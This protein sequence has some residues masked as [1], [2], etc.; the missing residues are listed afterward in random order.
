MEYWICN[1][2]FLCTPFIPGAGMFAANPQRFIQ[3]Y[4][5]FFCYAI[6]GTLTYHIFQQ[7][8][9]IHTNLRALFTFVWFKWWA[10]YSTIYI[11]Y[12]SHMLANTILWRWSVA[13]QWKSN[14]NNF[15]RWTHKFVPITFWNGKVKSEDERPDKTFYFIFTAPRLASV[16][17][18]LQLAEI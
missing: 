1:P 14:H 3:Q 2:N 8:N 7:S 15:I 5:M 12:A 6:Y 17:S 18:P 10:L 13:R 4:A 11:V 9:L 16:L